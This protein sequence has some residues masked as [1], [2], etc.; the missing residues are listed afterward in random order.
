MMYTQVRDNEGN[1]YCFLFQGVGQIFA[2][3]PTASSQ[4]TVGSMDARSPGDSA[5]DCGRRRPSRRNAGVIHGHTFDCFCSRRVPRGRRRTHFRPF[6]LAP[7]TPRSPAD[8]F[9]Y[10]FARAAYPEVIGGHTSARFRVHHCPRGHRRPHDRLL[11]CP[12]LSP[13][14]SSIALAKYLH[15]S[16]S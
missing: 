4:R 11:S 8:A 14:P 6:L 15:P 16:Q 1:L 12:P 13:R 10:I 5:L 2:P 3:S 9:S 7:R